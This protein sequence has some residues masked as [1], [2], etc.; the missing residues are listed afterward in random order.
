MNETF[1][2]VSLFIPTRSTM[3]RVCFFALASTGAFC[4]TVDPDT[5]VSGLDPTTVAPIEED[6]VPYSD[7]TLAEDPANE[8]EE[9]NKMVVLEAVDDYDVPASS[10][11]M[12]A[13]GFL[14]GMKAVFGKL[15]GLKEDE[16][17]DTQRVKGDPCA[18][19]DAMNLGK[20]AVTNQDV[21]IMPV[22]RVRQCLLATRITHQDA[23]WTLHNMRHGVAETY[24][25]T[26]IV[27]DT[28]K[29]PGTN[30]C[31]HRVHKVEIDLVQSIRKEL[32]QYNATISGMKSREEVNDFL[33]QERSAYAFHMSLVSL[34]NKLHDAHTYYQSPYDMFRVYFPISF[35]SRMEGE[36]QVVTL[37]APGDTNLELG[38]LVHWHDQ[39]FSGDRIPVDRDG[40]II[41][42]VNGMPALDFLK[43]LVEGPLASQYQQMEQ[44]L[45]AYIFSPQVIT[46]VQTLHPLPEYDAIVIRF[47]DG[48]ERTVHL[49]G[50]F[51]DRL[52][53]KGVSSLKNTRKL[54][55]YI[56]SNSAFE[57]F[58]ASDSE[59]EEKKYTLWK[60]ARG[61]AD[62]PSASTSGSWAE[63]ASLHRELLDPIENMQRDNLLLLP[64][65]VATTPAPRRRVLRTEDTATGPSEE[66]QCPETFER[67]LSEAMMAGGFGIGHSAASFTPIG[68]L[69]YKFVDKTVV[70]RV[71]TFKPPVAAGVHYFPEFVSIQQEAM[72]REVTRVLFDV[73]GN[74]GGSVRSAYALMWY[75]MRDESKICAP[76]R[77]RMTDKWT[78]WLRSFAGGF[79]NL[80]SQYMAPHSEAV[81]DN[82]ESIFTQIEA[83]VV[84]MHEGLGIEAL[85]KGLPDKTATLQAI[86]R[87]KDEIEGIKDKVARGDAIVAYLRTRDFLCSPAGQPAAV[88]ARIAQLKDYL[89]PELWMQPFRNGADKEYSWPLRS[90]SGLKNY[91]QPETKTWGGREGKYSQR[92]RFSE[93]QDL[94]NDMPEQA[95]GYVKNY[96]TQVSFVSDGT[97]GSACALFTQGIQTNGDAVAFTYGGLANEPLD[98]AAFA[99]GNV[100]GY[101]DFWSRA[102]FQAKAARLASMGKAPWIVQHEKSWVSSPM[103]FPTRAGAAF[104]RNM[105]FVEAMGEDALP[106][107]FYLIPGRRHFKLWGSDEGTK[108]ELYG[109]IAAI[110]DWGA[111]EPQ[112]AAT[113]G[114]CPMEARPFHRSA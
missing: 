86:K 76:V 87:K 112:F 16:D 2:I 92:A 24:S 78:L 70:V 42:H 101:K 90:I 14:S 58:I 15:L 114:Q 95:S 6:L 109:Q 57:A 108:N 8:D 100:E 66:L 12:E 17:V 110:G 4:A 97:C 72:K 13:G 60:F 107:Q 61:N 50:Q 80:L 59:A 41:T 20:T 38:R 22:T 53:D 29:N 10:E 1:S 71:P 96:W 30:A 37:R 74:G 26:D 106:R 34:L 104:N 54:N 28:E 81:A 111:V 7:E 46:L 84:L 31:G 65:Q 102:T 75:I 49:L 63:L 68:H 77:H 64:K 69:S 39:M 19:K 51:T 33:A 43:S 5:V 18:F 105:M 45:N 56:N 91:L 35:G 94:F 83:L 67:M 52:P 82:I 79:G 55:N 48:A 9:T 103:P 89:L 62:A 25:F 36:E 113:H 23:I 40:A 85:L 47:E 99:G 32:L 44:R 3:K 98:V 21:Y 11:P 73:S 27:M 93:C 88:A